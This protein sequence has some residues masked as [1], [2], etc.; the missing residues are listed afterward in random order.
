V[1]R[2]FPVS[3]AAILI[4][5]KQAGLAEYRGG[6]I[7]KLFIASVLAWSLFS[8]AVVSARGGSHGG[9][10][11][12]VSGYTRADGTY[13]HDYYRSAPGAAGSGNSGSSLSS[14]GN[15]YDGLGPHE[16]DQGALSASMGSA[17][18]SKS[19]CEYK[20]V[21]TDEEIAKCR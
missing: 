16:G 11:V 4:N 6:K 9:G 14:G 15:F 17:Q 19:K 3:A 13:V 1:R 21:M 7:M 10:S 8:P 2:T 18:P 5:F 12:H 20:A